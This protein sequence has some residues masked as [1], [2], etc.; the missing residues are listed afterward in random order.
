MRT[1][2]I[3]PDRTYWGQPYSAGDLYKNPYI[4]PAEASRRRWLSRPRAKP[5]EG[6]DP[7]KLR[8]RQ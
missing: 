8:A 5:P 3:I 1:Q 2:D 7:E 4:D 6:Y